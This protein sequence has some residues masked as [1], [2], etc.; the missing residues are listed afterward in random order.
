[1]GFLFPRYEMKGKPNCLTQRKAAR[2]SGKPIKN[3]SIHWDHMLKRQLF[4]KVSLKNTFI[5]LLSLVLGL[6][7]CAGFSLLAPSGGYCLAVVYRLLVAS[8][9]SPDAECWLWSVGSEVVVLGFSC[10]VACEIFP[11]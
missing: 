11:D 8:Q 2:P 5:Y 4:L 6:P 9:A 1:M 10:T 7:C 3:M